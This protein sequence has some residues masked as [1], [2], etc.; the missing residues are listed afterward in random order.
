M[1][2][3]SS[4]GTG[5]D[6]DEAQAWAEGPIYANASTINNGAAAESFDPHALAAGEAVTIGSA[7]YGA[8]RRTSGQLYENLFLEI[9]GLGTYAEVALSHG[10]GG[11]VVWE[12]P[13]SQTGNTWI[14]SQITVE[15]APSNPEGAPPGIF[16]QYG[17]ADGIITIGD[18]EL[19]FRFQADGDIEVSGTLWDLDG[20]HQINETYPGPVVTLTARQ[21]IDPDTEIRQEVSMFGYQFNKTLETESYLGEGLIVQVAAKTTLKA[22]VGSPD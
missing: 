15:G 18:T 10:S 13:E 6:Y 20:P 14:E 4:G 1:I 12:F 2:S 7:G 11:A 5:P 3:T 22:Y 21:Y 19:E 9:E 8:A 16:V 17:W